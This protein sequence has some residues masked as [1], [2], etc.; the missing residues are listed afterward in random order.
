VEQDDELEMSMTRKV[1]IRSIDEN[2]PEYIMSHKAPPPKINYQG[3]DLLLDK[4]MP[5]YCRKLEA[6]DDDWAEFISWD[7]YDKS[8]A[9]ILTIEQWSENTFEASFGKVVQYFQVSNIFPAPE[10]NNDN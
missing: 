10:Q 7:Y 4:E 8:E 3:M 1:K 9:F 2:L 6:S 5:G